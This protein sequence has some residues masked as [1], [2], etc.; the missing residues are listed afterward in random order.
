MAMMLVLSLLIQDCSVLYQTFE[1]K[2]TNKLT[3]SSE[4]C[5]LF[6]QI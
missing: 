5:G 1:D 4:N 2:L 3:I 6:R